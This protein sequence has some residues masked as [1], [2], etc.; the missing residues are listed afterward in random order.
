MSRCKKRVGETAKDVFQEWTEKTTFH[1]VPNIYT[2]YNRSKLLTLIWTLFFVASAI[3]CAI[4][5]TKTI[6][7]YY[8][9]DTVISL[10]VLRDSPT[11]FPAVTICNLQPFYVTDNNYGYFKSILAKTEIP[12]YIANGS[13][14]LNYTSRYDLLKSHIRLK[15][16]LAEDTKTNEAFRRSLGYDLYKNL[17]ISCSYN[18]L[19]ECNSSDFS[20]FWSN[21]YGNCYTFNDGKN[22]RPVRTTSETGS[23]TG[24][25]LELILGR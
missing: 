10:K 7:G 5:V 8:R 2:F 13:I 12:Y 9:Y 3:L 11:L 18:G 1:G 21:N 19:F 20:Y 22:G 23:Y 17:M 16:G 14:K 4:Y 6:I 25:Q 15:R 24:L